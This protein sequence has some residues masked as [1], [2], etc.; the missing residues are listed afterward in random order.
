MKLMLISEPS[1]DHQK[2]AVDGVLNRH[3]PSNAVL[4]HLHEITIGVWHSQ[5]FSFLILKSIVL[6]DIIKMAKRGANRK[7]MEELKKR[8]DQEAAAEV[9]IIFHP[10]E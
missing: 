10:F 1:S 4:S 5:V 2:V 6:Q 3:P 9:I 7:E 8:Q